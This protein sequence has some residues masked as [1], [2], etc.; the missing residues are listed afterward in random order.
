LRT[1]RRRSSRCEARCRSSS[2]SS[3]ASRRCTSRGSRMD[4][5]SGRYL[6]F[7]EDVLIC[8]K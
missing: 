3:R 8:E 5:W 2:A 6:R 4:S 7:M 1:R